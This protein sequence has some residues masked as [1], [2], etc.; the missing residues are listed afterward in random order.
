MRMRMKKIAVIVMLF[1]LMLTMLGGCFKNPKGIVPKPTASQSAGDSN[2]AGNS[3]P[4][5]NN[6][7]GEDNGSENNSG[8]GSVEALKPAGNPSEG[9]ANYSTYKSAAYDRITTLAD[10]D[11]SI[12]MTVSF[13]Y[14]GVAMVDLSLLS[15]TL[16]T[17]DLQSSEM[18]MGMLGMEGAK[19][20]NSGN[21]YTIT[22]K[23]SDGA[24]FKQTCTYDPGK[25][26][27]SSTLYDAD[28]KISIFFEY[29]FLGDAYAA[30]YYYPSNEAYEIIRAYF[31]KD[32]VAAFGILKASDEPASILN[33]SGFNAE[34][35]KNDQS[36]VVL[37]DGKLTVFDNGTTTTN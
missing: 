5:A 24:S 4:A 8:S 10:E 12:S 11:D 27:L 26:Q 37:V 33:K 3:N 29:V 19:I 17:G 1:A 22:Y 6:G 21:D 13:G 2:T 16:M 15:L 32:N 7:N 14:L 25:D 36:Y 31:D 18:A 20:T 30:Q 23:D 35:V 9:F 28:G 34:F